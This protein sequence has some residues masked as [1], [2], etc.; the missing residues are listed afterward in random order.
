MLYPAQK[1][2]A[3]MQQRL[4][5]PPQGL[6]LNAL[7]EELYSNNKGK[8]VY[9]FSAGPSC[10]APEVMEEVHREF[11]NFEGSGMSFME[12]SHRD[13]GGPVQLCMQEVC[14]LFGQL[15]NIP[16]NYK[17]LLFQS[18]AHAQFAAVPLN[19]GAKKATYLG[20]GQWSWRA[21]AEASMY[22]DVKMHNVAEMNGCTAIPP[23][24][25]WAPR[26]DDDYVYVCLNETIQGLEFHD[27]SYLDG[28][29]GPPVIADGTSTLLSRPMDVSKYGAIFASAGKN[30]GPAGLTVL[31]VR[32]DLLQPE[33]RGAGPVPSVLDWY[34][35]ATSLP[36][37]NVYNT[38][39]TFLCHVTR[40]VLKDLQAKGGVRWAKRRAMERSARLYDLIDNSQGFFVNNVDPKD[41]S[42]MN[43]PFRVV[44]N[45]SSNSGSSM[46]L[47]Y[48]LSSFGSARGIEQ[49]FGHPL[50]GGQR[51]SLYNGIPDAAVDK[52]VEL[53]RD[54][55]SEQY[56][57][58]HET[59]AAMEDARDEEL[60]R[61][62]EV[63]TRML[64]RII[65]K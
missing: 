58:E 53:M 49:L 42:C 15:L 4:W 22:C 11:L 23:L 43:V 47:E 46:D 10:L 54:F 38:P 55:L 45:P 61:L 14:A 6:E 35:Q 13:A 18:G 41:R 50:H 32:E 30:I 21:A 40:L 29:E 5:K 36:I 33:W 9:N 24:R 44:A 26:E 52:V 39:P 63:R 3:P 17:V 51:V 12:M 8:R 7:R 1:M 2:L 19:L 27:E 25:D 20:T 60:E 31:I 59:L 34:K 48:A 65:E 62:H 57:P 64:N 56:V 16:R 28:Y 37:P